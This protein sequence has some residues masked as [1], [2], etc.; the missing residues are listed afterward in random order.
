MNITEDYNSLKTYY[1]VYLNTDQTLVKTS[2]DEPTPI[3]CV[4]EMINKI[5]EDTWKNDNLKVLDPCCGCGNFFLVILEKLKKYHNVKDILE[6]MLYFNDINEDRLTVVK[7]IFMNDEYNLNISEMDYLKYDEEM[8][9]DIV[10]ANPPYAKLLPNGKRAS[11]NHNLIGVFIDKTLKILKEGGY[12]LY[13]TPDNWMTFS[14][15]NT[16][17][18]TLTSLQILYINIHIAKKYFKKIGSSFTWYLIENKKSYKDVEIDGIWKGNLYKSTVESQVRRYIPLYYNG[19]IQSILK[20][21]IDASNT[22]FKVETS[23]DLHKYT[24]KIHIS[25]QKTD[26]FKYKLIHTPKQT[27]WANRPHKYQTGYKVF[28]S[29]TTYYGVFVDNCGMTQSI[30]FIRCDNKKKAD[31]IKSVLEHPLYVFI[32]NICRYGNFNNIRILQNFPYCDN[33]EKIYETFKITI[34][35]QNFINNNM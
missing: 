5:P 4:E 19:I 28:I 26:E 32:N 33:K 15:R 14:D 27:V 17:I 35:E 12:M 13:I 23:S 10:V 11:K 9:Y 24:K 31:K 34:E 6:N 3:E 8:K 1:N 25:N 16:L 29:T 2:N 18:K 7:E 21:T 30:A 22:K 20:K